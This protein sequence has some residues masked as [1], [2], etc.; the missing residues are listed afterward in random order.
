ME[1]HRSQIRKMDDRKMK[2]GQ[3]EEGSE[4]E[5]EIFQVSKTVKQKKMPV[6]EQSV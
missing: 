6:T 3:G 2:E 5:R 4:G 1:I